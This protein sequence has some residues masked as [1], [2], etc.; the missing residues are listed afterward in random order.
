MFRQS[1]YHCLAGWKGISPIY[2]LRRVLTIR[3]L[4]YQHNS[5]DEPVSNNPCRPQVVLSQISPITHRTLM[6]N[7][8]IVTIHL[9]PWTRKLSICA[10]SRRAQ[11][12]QRISQL[13]SCLDDPNAALYHA[14]IKTAME[15]LKLFTRTRYVQ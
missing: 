6:N 1:C 15:Y 13:Q 8:M 14:G 4:G 10:K 2:A 9:A 3:T 12:T 7:N 5:S 11:Y